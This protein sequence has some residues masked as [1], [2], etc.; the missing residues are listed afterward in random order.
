MQNQEEIWKDVPNYEGLYQV[1]NY[2]MVKSL[3][4][5][6]SHKNGN[7]HTV[8]EKILKQTMC[9]GYL[10]VTL[11][12]NNK[13]KNFPIHKL[14]A[15]TFLNHVPCGHKLVV[16]HIDNNQLNNN[17][18][19]LQIITS[20]ENLSKDKKNF[21]SKFIGVSWCK[22]NKKFVSA[23][24]IEGI[25][26]SLGHFD[27]EILASEAYQKTLS[28]YEQFGILPKPR[29]PYSKHKGIGFHK[30]RNK[31]TCSINKKNIGYY[32][33]EEEAYEAYKNNI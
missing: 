25:R 8:K 14:L 24:T 1:S 15:V 27:C 29:V 31:W 13:L 28:E 32:N 33:S 18:D 30:T 11:C 3:E 10:K 22:T 26:K 21:T 4:R 9:K 16:D 7:F 6:A 2:G 5:K 19:N 17:L 12:K 20:R 23:I